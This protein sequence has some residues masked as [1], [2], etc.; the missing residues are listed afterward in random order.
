M[1][2]LLA[3]LAPCVSWLLARDGG[4]TTAPPLAAAGLQFFAPIP[5]V[6]APPGAPGAQQRQLIEQV[7]LTDHT[8]CSYLVSSQYPH[9]SRPAAHNPDQL[10]PNQPLLESNPLRAPGGNSDPEVMLQTAQSRVYL[11]AGES[12][13]LSLRALDARGAALPLVVT[14]ALAQGLRYDGQQPGPR[15]TL[16]F[17]ETDGAW[18]TSLTPAQGA[19][20]AFHGTIRAE[21]RYSASGRQGVVLFDLLYSPTLPAQWSGQRSESREAGSLQFVLGLDVRQPGRYIVSGRVDDANGRPFALASFNDLLA[22]GE[23]Q[24]RLTVFGKLLHDGAP[25]LPLVLRDVD[26]YLLRENAD[27]D[28]LLVPRLEGKVLASTARSLAGFSNAEW[29]SEERS[30][31]LAEYAKDRSAAR[32]ALARFDPGLAPPASVCAAPAH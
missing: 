30:R 21:V 28:R 4:E 5:A 9:E 24:V 32:S 12:A 2:A 20:A 1:C 16:D 7:R 8:Y 22:A 10:Y 15:V 19:L 23:R 25:A 31:Y 29:Q 26:G 27:P 13:T 11:A 3:A 6:E 14:R 17:V 18:R